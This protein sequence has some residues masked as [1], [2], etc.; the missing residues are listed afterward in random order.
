MIA[1]FN[2]HFSDVA[3]D[4]RKYRPEYPSNLFAFVSFISPNQETA[5]DCATGTGQSAR[6]LAQSF[7]QVIAT[8]ASQAQIN[9]A[10]RS[11]NIH[12]R[13]FPAEKTNIDDQSIDL[14]TVAQALHWFDID[15]FFIEANRVLKS[16]GVLAVWSYNL[17]TINDELDNVIN[18]FYGSVLSKYWPP[19]RK[20][21][22]DRYETIDF[23]FQEI[24]CPPFEMTTNW[25]FTQLLGYL[26]TWSAVV[27]YREQHGNN[28]ID[29]IQDKLEALWGDPKKQLTV[30][31]PLT[32]KVRVK[33]N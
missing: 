26:N 2:D 18:E 4:Y 17:L 7:S 11:H 19:E 1:K 6:V 5:W 10:T 24:Q 25:K 21:V 29:D 22:E 9:Q 23:P 31:W 30:K 13:V 20:F 28:P 3:Q 14:I 15:K 16:G 33:P 27:N 8:D 12:Y 32:V